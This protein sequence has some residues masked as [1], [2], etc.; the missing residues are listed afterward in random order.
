MKPRMPYSFSRYA[1]TRRSIVAA[2]TA[3]RSS[4]CSAARWSIWRAPKEA[5]RAVAISRQAVTVAAAADGRDSALMA[6]A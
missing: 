6:R 2:T 4:S 1:S 3:A 5:A